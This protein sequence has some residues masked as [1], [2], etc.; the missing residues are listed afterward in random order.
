MYNC[1]PTSKGGIVPIMA[2]IQLRANQN[3][4]KICGDRAK[5]IVPNPQYLSTEHSSQNF[6]IFLLSEEG[7]H[8]RA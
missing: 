7:C 1:T 3:N 2:R 8:I 5:N 4:C 6:V